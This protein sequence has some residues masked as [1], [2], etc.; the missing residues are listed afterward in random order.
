[1]LDFW[2]G[3]LVRP[4]SLIIYLYELPVP[5]GPASLNALMWW[6]IVAI[7]KYSPPGLVG[8]IHAVGIVS[9]P[10]FV[11]GIMISY[12]VW[13]RIDRLAFMKKLFY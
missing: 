11:T 7:L 3:C 4:P 8:N 1:M 6:R 9:Q 13:Q 5:V 12:Q 10:A 2:I